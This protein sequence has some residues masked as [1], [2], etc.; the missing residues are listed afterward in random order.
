VDGPVRVRAA[1][2]PD[3]EALASV[4]ARTMHET[5]GADHD[6]AQLERHIRDNLAP[7]K[8]AA[9]LADPRMATFVAEG[10]RGLHG[11]A[12][13]S[14]RP[15]PPCVPAVAPAELSRIYVSANRHGTGV[16]SALLASILQECSRRGCD[17]LWVSVWDRNE[18]ACSFYRARGFRDA[19]TVPFVFGGVEYDDL[20]LARPVALPEVRPI[21]ADEGRLLRR[22]RLAA[23]RES[24]GAFLTTAAEAE[25]TPDEEWE[26]RA[27]RSAGGGPW[28]IFLALAGG[29]PCGLA[30]GVP[31]PG[32]SGVV[33]LVQMWVDPRHRRQGVGER[34][35]E[36]V[37]GWSAE[38]AGRVRLGVADDHPAAVALYRRAGFLPTGETEP[39]PG[40]PAAAILYFEKELSA[41]P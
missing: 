2:P 29:E 36:A 11:Y 25:R 18:R 37:L 39:A 38:R 19:G 4:A 8:I 26:D 40:R 16:G 1:G 9:E 41:R 23:L 7:E 21:R 31:A 15:A 3:V 12:T 13:L 6:P 20:V 22:V 35:V 5:Y 32:R 30:A 27:R 34:L 28:G 24:P 10:D 33:E 17:V 14:F